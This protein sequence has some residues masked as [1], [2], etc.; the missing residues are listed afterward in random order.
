MKPIVL[1]TAARFGAN[2]FESIL[3]RS[4]SGTVIAGELFRKDGEND[5]EIA[6]LLSIDVAELKTRIQNDPLDIWHTLRDLD[7]EH[8][9]VVRLYYYH[10]DR[11]SPI[12]EDIAAHAKVIHLTRR[13]LFDAYVSRQ[14]AFS[15]KVW[16][17]NSNQVAGTIAGAGSLTV[18]AAQA[19]KYVN[20]RLNDINWCRNKLGAG[21]YCEISFEDMCHS[22]SAGS[23]IVRQ[24]AGIQAP[25]RK[26]AT[27]KIHSVFSVRIKQ[28]CN[29]DLIANYNELAHLDHRYL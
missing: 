13:N 10:L 3:R 24:A 18:D 17:T 9:V 19:E 29:V 12:W 20:D 2:L 25:Q 28:I 21:D 27:E 11:A 22:N 26:T 4:T 14:I 15:S 7:T 23:L 6:N 16:R 1:V 5:K 8:P